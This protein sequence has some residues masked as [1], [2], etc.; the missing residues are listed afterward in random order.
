MSASSTELH[1]P[2]GSQLIDGE[3]VPARAKAELEVI[4]PATR[5]PFTTVARADAGDIEDAV[6]AARRAF[7]AWAVTNPSE[8]GALLRRWAELIMTAVDDL[9]AIEARD[10]GKPLAGGRLNIYIAQG[11]IDYFSGAADK[12]TGVTLPTR[13]PDYLGYT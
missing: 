4:D 10:V 9:A 1:Y 11:I 3:W 12:L 8:R 5:E 7:P 2:A 13:T 6:A